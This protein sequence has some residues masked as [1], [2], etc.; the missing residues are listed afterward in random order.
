MTEKLYYMDSHMARFTA[1]VQ[2]CEP[3]GERWAIVLDRT[4][5]FPGGG[6]QEP[7]TGWLGQAQVLT[8]KEQGEDVVHFTDRPVQAGSVVE[9]RL[10][11]MQR[12]RRMQ[13]HTGEHILSGLIHER[14]GLEN[15]GFHMGEDVITVDYNGELTTGQIYELERE[16]NLAVATNGPVIC[17]FPEQAEL[18][19]MEYRSK[20]ALTGPVRIVTVE[21]YDTCA[22]CA[23]HVSRTGEVGIIK[24]Y[25]WARHRGG[26]RIT[27]LCGMD[28]LDD[29]NA[30]CANISSISGLLSAK[31]LETAHAVARLWKEHEALKQK[32]NEANRTITAWKIQELPVCEGNMVLFEPDLDPVCLR[33]LVNGAME[34]C[35][36]IAA[37]F[38]GSD[39]EG[40]RY[41]IGSKTVDLRAEVKAIN[42]AIGGKGGGKSEMIQGTATATER[43]IRNY[44]A[45]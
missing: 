9:G 21:G 32:L 14:F 28:A 11:W 45:N 38:A 43:E 16:A 39:E 5:F 33:E 17:R 10:D 24:L 37:A 19:A 25:T 15:V 6:G 13:N 27:M 44:F 3:V 36:G 42:A 20:K 7:D 4:A 12:F 23:P 2:S 1:T 22:C 18:D 30:R 35:S 34:R 26:T 8:C 31:P 41:I 40:Y 29:Y